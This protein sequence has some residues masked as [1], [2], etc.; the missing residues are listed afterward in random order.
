MRLKR[1]GTEWEYREFPEPKETTENPGQYLLP[2]E[3]VLAFIDKGYHRDRER[4]DPQRLELLE[5]SIREEGLHEPILLLLDPDGKIRIHD[6]NHRLIVLQRLGH[7]K[8]PVNLEVKPK[9]VKGYGRK[10]S[11][12]SELVFQMF[13]KKPRFKLPDLNTDTTL[14]ENT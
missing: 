3:L 6:G 9:P 14:C 13:V 5:Q 12:N 11:D 2:M 8:V 10:L 7:S 4:H 1:Y